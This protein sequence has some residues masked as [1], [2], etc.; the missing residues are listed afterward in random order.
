M[1]LDCLSCRALFTP[2]EFLGCFER[3]SPAVDAM[4]W[5]CPHCGGHTDI[6][7]SRDE[8]HRG[9]VYGAGEAHFSDEHQIPVPGLRV[10]HGAGGLLVELGDRR[11]TVPIRRTS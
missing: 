10:A 9:Y 11:W 1:D 2:A 4:G 3:Y 5:R 6:R 8:V 7:L